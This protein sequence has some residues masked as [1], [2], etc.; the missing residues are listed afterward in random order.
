MFSYD[1]LDT[2]LE[3]SD[4]IDELYE[5]LPYES[6]IHDFFFMHL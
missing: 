1:R 6:L 2:M 4:R 3:I 5:E